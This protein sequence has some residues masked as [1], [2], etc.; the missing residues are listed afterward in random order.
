MS[1]R[2]RECP[3]SPQRALRSA[4]TMLA[5]WSSW[6]LPAAAQEPM[7]ARQTE[8][9]AAA[10]SATIDTVEVLSQRETLRKAAQAF[11]AS[12]T[13]R[14]GDDVARWRIPI[15][16]VV[17]GATPELNE[18]V[19]LRILAVAKTAGAATTADPA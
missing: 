2:E 6:A 14:D 16:S 19:R 9:L 18:F 10:T 17:S 12:I 8:P 11:V 13:R 15:C 4:C 7:P 5:L 1:R 3:F